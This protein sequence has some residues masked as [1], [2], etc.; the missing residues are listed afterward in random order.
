MNF[1]HIHIGRVIQEQVAL[2]QI[3]MPRI[4]K[5]LKVEEEEIEA[6][7]KDFEEKITQFFDYIKSDADGKRLIAKMTSTSSSFSN[8]EILIDFSKLYRKFTIKNKE[9]GEFFKRETKD[10]LTQLYDDFERTLKK[11]YEIIESDEIRMVAEDTTAKL[12]KI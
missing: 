10:I 5:F 2:Q 9:L 1:K 12:N 8:E 7:I 6:L 11:V 3:Q 4:C